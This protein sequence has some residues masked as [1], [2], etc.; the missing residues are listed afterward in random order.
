LF[1]IQT[2]IQEVFSN[3]LHIVATN[4]EEL[5]EYKTDVDQKQIENRK[6]FLENDHLKSE[7]KKLQVI[8]AEKQI[9]LKFL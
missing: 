2:D 6:L 5:Q 9:F 7:L 4:I 1:I 3:S 8:I